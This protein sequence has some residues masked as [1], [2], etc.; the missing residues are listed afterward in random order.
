MTNEVNDFLQFTKSVRLLQEQSELL[1][2]Q[3]EQ[4]QEQID[5]ANTTAAKVSQSLAAV[6][7]YAKTAFPEAYAEFQKTAEKKDGEDT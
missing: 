5:A 1:Q 3:S 2:K 7:A 4:L 6:M